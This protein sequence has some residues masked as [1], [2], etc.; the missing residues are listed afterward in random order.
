M[1]SD[2]QNN[3][4]PDYKDIALTNH[5][6]ILVTVDTQEAAQAVAKILVQERLAACINIFPIHSIYIWEREL[7]QAA[8]W[9]MVIK[10]DFNK[11]AEIELKL[12]EV[13]P[14]DVPEMIALPIQQ[15]TSAY[16]AWMAAQTSTD[17]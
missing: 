6:V 10:T 15:G 17:H 4:F 3:L 1:K 9:Q 11:F 2:F 14:Y 13:H 12:N 16:L 8:E 7:Q 5:T